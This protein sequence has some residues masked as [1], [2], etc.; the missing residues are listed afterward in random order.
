MPKRK[1]PVPCYY[2]A[3]ANC[4]QGKKQ[5]LTSFTPN[6]FHYIQPLPFNSATVSLR[7]LSQ[8]AHTQRDAFVAAASIILLFFD[9]LDLF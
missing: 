5:N 8:H 2:R 3:I 9:N 6:E 7:L 1:D 4:V